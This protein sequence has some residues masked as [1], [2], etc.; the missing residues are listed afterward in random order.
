MGAEGSGNDIGSE[1]SPSPQ[2]YTVH[3]PQLTPG[4]FFFTENL[5]FLRKHLILHLI[6]IRECLF[7]T[8]RS[9]IGNRAMKAIYIHDITHLRMHNKY[10]ERS[11]VQEYS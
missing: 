5:G 9:K 11:H 8:S 3:M 6:N 4:F 1:S 2:V 10:C 7:P